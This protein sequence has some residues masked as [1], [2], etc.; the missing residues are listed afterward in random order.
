MR[1]LKRASSSIPSAISLQRPKGDEAWTEFDGRWSTFNLQVGNNS[2][3][4][5]FRFVP[6]TSSLQSWVTSADTCAQNV[7][8]TFATT[9][10]R[11]PGTPSTPA[12]CARLRGTGL[13]QAE[14]SNGYVFSY[15]DSA[16]NLSLNTNQNYA[17][18]FG[19]GD[20]PVQRYGSVYNF[21]NKLY[22]DYLF[23]SDGSG[24]EIT[25]NTPVPVF[26]DSSL[27]VYTPEIG[28]GFGETDIGTDTVPSLLQALG[29]AA[30]IPSRSWGYTAGASY[31]KIL[32]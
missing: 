27:Y 23:F 1:L 9:L 30:V 16:Q 26:A 12:D 8:D 13:Y 19:D 15:S 18:E 3:G 32:G 28:L 22:A 17:I 24:G 29:D 21:N 7:L 14:Q 4:Q 25:S 5:N 20:N 10:G 2:G 31:S 6:S 11:S